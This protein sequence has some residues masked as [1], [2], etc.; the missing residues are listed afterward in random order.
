MWEEPDGDRGLLTVLVGDGLIRPYYSPFVRDGFRFVRDSLP[1]VNSFRR[2]GDPIPI[3]YYFPTPVAAFSLSPGGRTWAVG[4][5]DGTITVFPAP[6]L[7]DLGLSVPHPGAGAVC[8]VGFM[9]D[10]GIVS[11]AQNLSVAAG[12]PN[13]PTNAVW[14][15][16]GS[17]GQYD[18]HGA[19]APA[20]GLIGSQ[21]GRRVAYR[22]P[23]KTENA[24]ARKS[25]VV[26]VNGVQVA[27]AATGRHLT[28]LPVRE[29]VSFIQPSIPTA[30][31]PGREVVV[32]ANPARGFFETR[33]PRFPLAA[34]VVTWDVTSGKAVATWPVTSW[35]RR[36]R[37]HR[38]RAE[39]GRSGRGWT[40]ASLES[41]PT[42]ARPDPN[43]PGCRRAVVGGRIGRWVEACGRRL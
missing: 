20:A 42:G 17:S 29:N 19:T 36:N 37:C 24:E 1:V 10:G 14:T 26:L 4:E 11:Q 18:F 16:P 31:I 9:A 12:P 43:V 5:A 27:D 3:P 33:Q 23:K 35:V 25:G 40:S 41:G 6:T 28:V 22:L 34:E 15:V 21:D 38:R 2:P 8:G 13:Q 7:T 30:F 39:C 32:Y